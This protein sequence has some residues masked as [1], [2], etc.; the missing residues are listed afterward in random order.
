MRSVISIKLLCDFIEIT[1]RHRC[2]PVTLLLFLEHLLLRT[3]LGRCFCKLLDLV[4]NTVILNASVDLILSSKRL[5][6][7]YVQ[8]IVVCSL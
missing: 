7:P 1:L 8:L 3:S 4:S 2:S 5:D 6:I